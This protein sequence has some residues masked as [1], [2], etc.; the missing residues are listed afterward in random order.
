MLW[1]NS[2]MQFRV[3]IDESH[4]LHIS[5]YLWRAAPGTEAPKQ[6]VDSRKQ[7]REG[8]GLAKIV[9]R[10]RA[11]TRNA[12]FYGVVRGEDQNTQVGTFR[13]ELAQ[14]V[15]SVPLRQREI[16]QE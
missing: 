1:H 6:G 9:I 14:N 8:E 12:V 5:L 7:L 2:T 3:P 15:Q 4:T 13:P 11:K 10:T 16:E